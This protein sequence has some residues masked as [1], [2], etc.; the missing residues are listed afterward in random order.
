MFFA[1][2]FILTLSSYWVKNRNGSKNNRKQCIKNT[3]YVTKNIE[4]K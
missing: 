1:T 3:A 2:N 4:R